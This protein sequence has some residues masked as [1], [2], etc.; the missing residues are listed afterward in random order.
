MQA[1]VTRV[2]GH[3]V[4]RKHPIPHLKPGSGRNA[5]FAKTPVQSA[6]VAGAFSASTTGIVSRFPHR[7]HRTGGLVP[8]PH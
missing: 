6:A 1:Q 2:A 3:V 8:K 4:V 7:H 5:A